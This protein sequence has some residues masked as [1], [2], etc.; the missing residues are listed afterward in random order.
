MAEST[1]ITGAFGSE[2]VPVPGLDPAQGLP[3]AGAALADGAPVPLTDEALRAD[4]RIGP[5]YEARQ[6]R[7]LRPDSSTLEAIG[8]AISTWDTTGLIKR[9]GRPGFDNDTPINQYEYLQNVPLALSKDEREYF[10]DTAV[11]VKSADYAMT[12]IRNRRQAQEVLG[13]H[14]LVGVATAFADPLWLAV[15]PAVRIGG[16]AGRAGRAASA[17]TGAGIAGAVTASQEGPVS[18]HEIAL[19]M[20][21]NGAAA[22]VLYREG[23]LVKADPEFPQKALDSAVRDIVNPQPAKP[24]YR[25]VQEAVYEDVVTPAREAAF[26]FEPV[27]AAPT[28]VS[29]SKPRY[30]GLGVTFEN[31]FDKAAYIVA[32]RGKSAAHDNI[33]NWVVAQTGQSAEQIIARGNAIRA[34]LKV[35]AKDAD[36]TIAAGPSP[37]ATPKPQV[38]R[39]LAQAAQAERTDRVLKSPAKYELIPPELTPGYVNTDPAKVAQA[40]ETV[41]ADSAVVRG[42]AKSRGEW[43]QWN[44]HKTMA[45]YGTEGRNIASILY[46]N[47]AD[48][49][50][51]SIES[52]RES[53][54]NGLRSLQFDYEDALRAE[55]SRRGTGTLQRLNPFTSRDAMAAQ[56]ELEQQVTLELFKREQ[57]HRTGRVMPASDPAVA[58]LADR[59]DALMKRSLQELKTAG[60]VGAEE[61]MN[62][63][64]YLP[65]RWNAQKIDEVLARIQATGATAEQALTALHRLV[66]QAVRRGSVDMPRRLSEQIGQAIVDRALRKGYFE[67]SI[68][69]LPAGEGQLKE[70]RDILREAKVPNE[71]AERAIN[72]LRVAADDQGKAGFLK[73]RMDLDYGATVRIGNEQIGV[74]EL[75][76]SDVTGL[77]HQYTQNVATNSA[78]AQA[79]YRTRTSIDE[80]RTALLH[81]VADPV[82]RRKAADLFDNTLKHMRGEPAGD[83][84]P[85]AFRLAQAFN[86]TI[87]LAWSGL[88]QATEYAN[89]AARY[90]LSKTLKYAS[91][92]IPGFRGML[93]AD[94]AQ[95]RSLQ[96]V[97]SDQSVQSMRLRPYLQRYEDGYEMGAGSAMQLSMQTA[98]Q[99][100]PYANAMKFVH[101][102]QA[103]IVG[104]L[105]VDTLERGVKGDTKARDVLR[106]YGIEPGVLDRLGA[107]MR[108]HGNNVD[109]WDAQVWMQVR[110]A[111]TKMMDESVLKGRLGDMPAFAQFNSV[112]KFVFTYRSFVLTAHNKLLA[113]NLD[114]NGL[115]AVGLIMLYQYP[116]AM[117]AVQ[118][119]AT[120]KGDGQLPAD[121]LIARSIGQMGGIGL[122]S[123]PFKWAMGE[124]NSIGAPGL[125]AFDRGVTLFQGVAQGDGVKAG[126]AAAALFPVLNANPIFNGMLTQTKKD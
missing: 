88:W 106:G 28:P 121:K 24:R 93:K 5:A 90:G 31:D 38:R 83:N 72:V 79:G 74:H 110:P 16:L 85:E 22:G 26:K 104:N 81:G 12:Q 99:L 48:Y 51:H 35:R 69:G 13:D 126:T 101:H 64:G 91:Q 66:G 29:T 4:P 50:R 125:I 87:S 115:G 59:V 61:I 46:D 34:D 124:S 75:I 36:G 45:N 123:E 82:E 107:E 20:L 97:L 111:F 19:S 7:A 43:L 54:L 56:R 44:M 114:R 95:A 15:P 119:N 33:L 80:L 10:L 108:T 105:V 30:Q 57:G 9:L 17:A 113:G 112:G 3:A 14:E 11:G 120:L 62:R 6:Q 92:E 37:F 40:A 55:L 117:A 1:R 63:P 76:D 70:L 65:R 100:V 47:V 23:K 109:A 21:M 96:T 39:V 49:S 52:M 84:L 27:P 89:I 32:G 58:A 67:D 77:L 60:V 118:A 41:L 68:F 25:L 73:H 98:G 86:R 18:D 122:L 116:L 2:R 8:A 53:S 103:R 94:A 42:A 71:D 78:F 102:N